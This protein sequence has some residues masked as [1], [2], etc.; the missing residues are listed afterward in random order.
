MLR[1]RPPFAGNNDDVQV[2]YQ[3]VHEAVEPVR[4]HAPH[5][6]AE[7]EDVVMRALAKEPAERFQS[8]R[9]LARGARARRREAGAAP[10]ALG[11]TS[12]IERA[13][14]PRTR[15]FWAALAVAMLLSGAALGALAHAPAPGAAASSSCCRSR[16]APTILVDGKPVGDRTPA[17]VARPRAR[18][19][20]A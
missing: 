8:T 6:P 1:G 12:V 13:P 9:E 5:V 11:S 19:S 18:R 3:Q 4:V 15:A 10:V 7:L 2:L 20:I 14:A 17:R 16:P